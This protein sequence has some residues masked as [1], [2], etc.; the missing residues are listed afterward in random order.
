MQNFSPRE[1]ES[2]YETMNSQPKEQNETDAATSSS[3]SA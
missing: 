2:E 3:L 1:Q